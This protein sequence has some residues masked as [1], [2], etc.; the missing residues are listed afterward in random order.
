MAAQKSVTVGTSAVRVDDPETD[1]VAGRTIVIYNAGAAA[2]Y[3]G[4]A[5]DVTVA[6][7]GGKGGTPVAPSSYG[8][9][10]DLG[11]GEQVWAIS[12]SA[13]NDVRVLQLGV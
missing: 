11:Y 5:N 1:T 7:A 4:G 6:A 8:P 9:G 12:G 2:V 3:I 10:M 13:G